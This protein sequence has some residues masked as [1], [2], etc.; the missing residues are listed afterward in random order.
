[1]RTLTRVNVNAGKC[2]TRYK[3]TD[4]FENNVSPLKKNRTYKLFFKL[5]R[6]KI[7]C[8]VYRIFCSNCNVSYVGQ[9]KRKLKTRI[10]KRMMDINK[11]SSPSVIS[12]HRINKDYN[13]EWQIVEDSGQ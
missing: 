8:N 6:K 12:T 10:R 5:K 13:F 2:G 7:R 3:C 11:N 1:M 4:N 9:T